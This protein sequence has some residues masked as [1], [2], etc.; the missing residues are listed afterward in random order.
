MG[1]KKAQPQRK[2]TRSN[3][4]NTRGSSS[5]GPS[6]PIDISGNHGVPFPVY[7]MDEVTQ[8]KSIKNWRITK[9]K[10]FEM[11]YY[12]DLEAAG[13]E[14]ARDVMRYIRHMGCEELGSMM[15]PG[16]TISMH[17]FY[18]TFR[19]TPHHE[20]CYR[21]G[22]Q[23]FVLSKREVEEVFGFNGNGAPMGNFVA[24]ESEAFW[25]SLTNENPGAFDKKQATSIHDDAIF[26]CYK[27]LVHVVLNKVD[28]SVLSKNE[29]KALYLMMKEETVP[30]LPM[31]IASISA[32]AKDRRTKW[33]ARLT[34]G[35]HISMLAQY[36][37]I[38]VNNAQADN[39]VEKYVIKKRKYMGNWKD[40]PDLDGDNDDYMEEPEW[41]GGDDYEA[42]NYMVDDDNMMRRLNAM[43]LEAMSW[44][45]EYREDK[46][47]WMA[48][49]DDYEMN[50][51]EDEL[52]REESERD[53]RA[54]HEET[55]AKLD[56]ILAGQ[57]RW[58]HHGGSS[59][60]GPGL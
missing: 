12:E 27:F 37:N 31:M 50:H 56:A 9:P 8:Y 38:P 10:Q 11:Q 59:S 20:M 47:E 5:Q 33:P 24:R 46:Q 60:G 41:Q 57:A 42:N 22:G 34:F 14:L 58:G 4:A 25:T 2:N 17:E 32:I 36:H 15:G 40:I 18:T 1:P 6:E 45:N 30:I 26:V 55:N 21:L 13:N 49:R 7:T 3:T 19:V 54:R 44:Y 48:W 52:R 28:A 53:A 16:H 51:R 39:L 23:E 35:G 29:L 43:H